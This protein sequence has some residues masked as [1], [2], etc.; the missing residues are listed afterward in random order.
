MKVIDG[1]HHVA[2]LKASGKEAGRP[3]SM[4]MVRVHGPMEVS[5]MKMVAEGKLVTMNV[6][7]V[8]NTHVYNMYNV[9]NYLVRD[10]F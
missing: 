1:N 6:P 7:L 3:R 2:A 8:T 5:M 9:T 10:M 4:V